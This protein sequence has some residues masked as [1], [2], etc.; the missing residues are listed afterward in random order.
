[1]KLPPEF[2]LVGNRLVKDERIAEAK[3]DLCTRLKR[4]N[5]KKVRAVKPSLGPVFKEFPPSSTR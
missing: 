5:S 2:K 1:M 4:K 3:L